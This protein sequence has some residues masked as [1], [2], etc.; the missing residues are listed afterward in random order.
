MVTEP[1][2]KCRLAAKCVCILVTSPSATDDPWV[3]RLLVSVQMGLPTSCTG[4]TTGNSS[5]ALNPH[6]GDHRLSF[7]ED[8]SK[9]A[10]FWQSEEEAIW[11]HPRS[12]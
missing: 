12:K 1:G 11:L 2:S 8:E 7:L 5:E 9:L 4:G 3:W 6:A 10:S